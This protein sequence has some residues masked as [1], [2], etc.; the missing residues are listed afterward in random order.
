MGRQDDTCSH[1][2]GPVTS[3]VSWVEVPGCMAHWEAW[4]ALELG[5]KGFGLQVQGLLCRLKV[6]FQVLGSW[7]CLCLVSKEENRSEECSKGLGLRASCLWV[8]IAFQGE[9]AGEKPILLKGLHGAVV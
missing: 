5:D 4:S 2:R 6:R 8:P 1:Q 7:G 3:T 9:K